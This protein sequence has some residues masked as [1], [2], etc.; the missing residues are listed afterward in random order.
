MRKKAKHKIRGQHFILPELELFSR[1]KIM[2]YVRTSFEGGKTVTSAPERL[3][4]TKW[5]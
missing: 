5:H 1:D 4:L 3:D 2:L